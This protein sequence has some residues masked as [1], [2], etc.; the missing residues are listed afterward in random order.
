MI[1]RRRLL[2]DCLRFHSVSRKVTDVKYESM[3]GTRNTAS[4]VPTNET[5]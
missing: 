3:K 1:R 2:L 4:L 5:V